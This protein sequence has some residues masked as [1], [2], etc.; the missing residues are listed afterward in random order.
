[1]VQICEIWHHMQTVS[2]K[3]H[4]KRRYLFREHHTTN[5]VREACTYRSSLWTY[6]NWTQKAS[7]IVSDEFKHQRGSV[8]RIDIYVNVYHQPSPPQIAA[9][10]HRYK[11]WRSVLP[12]H[13]IL[14][15][16]ASCPEILLRPLI[17]QANLD[18]SAKPAFAKAL[19]TFPKKLDDT[20][21]AA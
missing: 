18:R 8:G 20:L 19:I 3:H 15:Y 12:Y 10:A 7:T 6:M 9:I 14:C 4:Y 21:S 17:Q 5:Q 2:S 11:E 1:M 13:L 16:Q